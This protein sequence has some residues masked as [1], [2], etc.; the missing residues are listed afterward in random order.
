MFGRFSSLKLYRYGSYSL[1][2]SQFLPPGGG[3]GAGMIWVGRR[4]RISVRDPRV[5]EDERSLSTGQLERI[6]SLQE[7][8]TEREKLAP[9]AEAR[10]FSLPPTDATDK[11]LRYEAHLDRQLYRA[12]DQLERQQRQAQRRQ[13]ASAAQH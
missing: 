12:M 6:R 11:L 9:D 3:L 8:A 10:S 4:L 5:F 13:R 1:R 2:R 7:Y